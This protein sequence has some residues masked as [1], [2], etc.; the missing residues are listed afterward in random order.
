MLQVIKWPT[1]EQQRQTAEEIEENCRLPGVIGFIDGSHIQ[2]SS[3]LQGEKD[4]FNRKGFH[5]I[6]LQVKQSLLKP[7]IRYLAKINFIP[8]IVDVQ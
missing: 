4:Y 5:S 8:V 6:K 1:P 7:K 2:L 3:A